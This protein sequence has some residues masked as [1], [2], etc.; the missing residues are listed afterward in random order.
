ML[1]NNGGP[2]FPQHP[3]AEHNTDPGMTLRDYFAGQALTG[4]ASPTGINGEWAAKRA[5]Q[6]ADKMLK[7]RENAPYD[8][9]ADDPNP[10]KV[11]LEVMIGDRVYEFIE[12]PAVRLRELTEHAL[13]RTGHK[14]ESHDDWK[15][16]DKVH[17]NALDL[18][19]QMRCF[20]GK[21]LFL[22]QSN[23]MFELH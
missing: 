6:Y 21:R 14:G 8:V 1:E 22:I 20:N 10:G 2:A 4:F 11:T 12:H 16:C 3:E 9:I 19:L 7:Q 18:D 23:M 17:G 5:Y 15:W 13:E